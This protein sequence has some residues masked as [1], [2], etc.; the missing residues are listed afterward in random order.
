MRKST[1][2]RYNESLKEEKNIKNNFPSLLWKKVW[3]I[4]TN[5]AMS[6]YEWIIID[7]E[8]REWFINIDAISLD[9]RNPFKWIMYV[10]IN[11]IKINK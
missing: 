9:I 6:L 2:E 5:S 7:D 4:W 3:F 10:D 1:I 11:R 8:P